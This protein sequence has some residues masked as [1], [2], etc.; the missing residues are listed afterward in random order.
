MLV[1]G[2]LCIG[3]LPPLQVTPYLAV[4]GQVRWMRSL[5]PPTRLHLAVAA[6]VAGG[7]FGRLTHATVGQDLRW[8]VDTG[9]DV[10]AD[11]IARLMS[12]RTGGTLTASPVL[13]WDPGTREYRPMLQLTG[14][15]WAL[16]AMD[17]VLTTDAHCRVRGTAFPILR[18]THTRLEVHRRPQMPTQVEEL[19]RGI[20]SWTP[21][22]QP[23]Q[24]MSVELVR[25]TTPADDRGAPNGAA[26]RTMLLSRT[27][28]N[29]GGQGASCQTLRHG[30]TEALIR[31]ITLEQDSLAG[32]SAASARFPHCPGGFGPAMSAER[33]AA[34]SA[35]P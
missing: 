9:G 20:A 23:G 5:Y 32:R 13:A 4:S 18:F 31:T 6:S 27:D 11:E 1:G 30:L 17:C 12:R 21:T 34:G 28:I 35:A 7:H 33:P 8:L 26:A 24:R 3:N 10:A 2:T 29:W 22:R 19:Q 14:G 25:L 15:A 16:A